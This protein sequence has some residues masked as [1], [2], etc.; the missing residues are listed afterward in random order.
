[1]ELSPNN[2][3]I[4]YSHKRIDKT[5]AINQLIFLFLSI[6]GLFVF[7]PITESVLMYGSAAV[8]GVPL[9]L[10]FNTIGL[11]PIIALAGMSGGQASAGLYF[12]IRNKGEAVNPLQWLNK[13]N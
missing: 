13:A 10:L 6:L 8:F 7:L 12:E 1:M 5:S 2:I 9:V 4:E 11:D 3:H